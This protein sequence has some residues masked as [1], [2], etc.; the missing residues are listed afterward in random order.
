MDVMLNAPPAAISGR[1]FAALAPVEG[2]M[3][4]TFTSV[5]ATLALWAQR[6][7]ERDEMRDMDPAERREL[8]LSPGDVS[9]ETDKWFWQK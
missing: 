3:W 8:S 1:T 4:T 6:M 7:R 2:R 9:C 5:K